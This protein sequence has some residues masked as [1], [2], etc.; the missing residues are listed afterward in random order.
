IMTNNHDTEGFEQLKHNLNHQTSVFIGQ[1][2]VGKSSLI[3]KVLPHEKNI[4]TQEISDNSELGKHTTSNSKY[5]HLPS[6]GALIDSPGVREFS[7]GDIDTSMLAQG[8][9]E[10]KPYLS[11]C[12]FR[13]CTH[14]QTPHCAII[15]A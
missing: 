15:E 12:K 2:G 1:S 3:S 9:T 7:L 13:N 5:F 4:A 8:Y 6:G 11:Q 14:I 10:F